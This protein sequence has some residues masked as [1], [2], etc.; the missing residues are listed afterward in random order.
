M[1]KKQS[2]GELLYQQVS[3]NDADAIRDLHREGADLEWMDR[4][5]RTPLIMA[6]IYE[7]YFVAKTLIELGANVNA[8]CPGRHAGTPLHHAAKM[9]R[10]NIVY[11]LL[12]R[13][14][15]PLVLNDDCQTPLE[16]ARDKG[17][18]Y[19]VHE[20]EEHIR[21]FSGWMREF[22]GPAAYLDSH[23][24][25]PSIRVWVVVVPTVSRNPAQPLKLEVVVYDNDQIHEPPRTVMR[26]WKANLEEPITNHSDISVIIVDESSSNFLLYISICCSHATSCFFF[27]FFITETHL[28]LAPSTKGDEQQLKWFY[29][30]C[31]GIPQPRGGFP[32]TA[33]SGPPLHHAMSETTNVNHHSVGEASSSTAPPPPPPSSGE[34]STS[35]LNSHESVIIHEHSPSAP[36][37]TDDHIETLEDG[38]VHYPTIDST[39]VDVPSSSPLPASAE[40]EKKEDG[41]SGQCSICL[42]A[43]SDVVCVPCGHLAGCM[44]CLTEI[45]SNNRGCPVCRAKIDQIIKLYRV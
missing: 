15:N 24:Q 23:Y 7:L 11:L 36:P 37:L 10:L 44:S 38:P 16:V 27:L 9:D 41:S 4:K 45:K 35:G 2:K 18:T 17:F 12:S 42:D 43:P 39:P 21:L 20:I 26:L 28:R 13:G 33:P 31:K 25:L 22:Y 34:G 5:G 32:Q 6:C 3:T 8:Y 1:R 29:D 30:A 19:V 40:G 14:A